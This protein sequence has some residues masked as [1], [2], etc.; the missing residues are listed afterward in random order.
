MERARPWLLTLRSLPKLCSGVLSAE[1]LPSQ[2]WSE[3]LSAGETEARCRGAAQPV[4]AAV[5]VEPLRLCCSKHTQ[6]IS[7]ELGERRD[8]L[9]LS[10]SL[11]GS[12]QDWGAWELLWVC[13]G[14]ST[15]GQFQRVWFM[16]L[17]MSC[18]EFWQSLTLSFKS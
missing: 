13:T 2:S 14:S 12:G 4:G 11:Q 6:F 5:R 16:T 18:P 8:L 3:L 7:P 15:Q 17:L 9:K 1:H 10:A